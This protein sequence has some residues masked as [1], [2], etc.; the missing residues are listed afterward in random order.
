MDGDTNWWCRDMSGG[1]EGDGGKLRD[2]V[3]V[4]ILVWKVMA[5]K[6]E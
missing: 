2:G 1:E 5:M 4:G 6:T 3:E